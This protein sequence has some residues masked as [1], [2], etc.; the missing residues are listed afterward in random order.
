[1]INYI[2]SL[3]EALKHC[4]ISESKIPLKKIGNTISNLPNEF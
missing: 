2:T 4:P 3:I 1:M